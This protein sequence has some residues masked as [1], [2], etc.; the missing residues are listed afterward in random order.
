MDDRN[1]VTYS[2]SCSCHKCAL[3]T[4]LKGVFIELKRSNSN[5]KYRYN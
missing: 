5:N 2:A 3:I 1:H 4:V